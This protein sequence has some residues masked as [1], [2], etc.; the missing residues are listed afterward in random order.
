MLKSQNYLLWYAK[1]THRVHHQVGN[2]HLIFRIYL[3]TKRAENSM[4]RITFINQLQLIIRERRRDMCEKESWELHSH[5]K[6][7]EQ[8]LGDWEIKK[9]DMAIRRQKAMWNANKR[10]FNSIL[11]CNHWF[12][13][14]CTSIISFNATHAWLTFS[15]NWKYTENVAHIC[16]ILWDVVVIFNEMEFYYQQ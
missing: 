1:C 12:K 16:E 11:K 15:C 2:W 8:V 13:A 7:E 5:K 9:F 6:I 3:A 4:W 10:L 14:F